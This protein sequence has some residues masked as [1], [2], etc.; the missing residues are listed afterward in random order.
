[1]QRNVLFLL[2]PVVLAVSLWSAVALAEPPDRETLEHDVFAVRRTWWLP[3]KGESF[4]GL[5]RFEPMTGEWERLRSL[6]F[7]EDAY[8]FIP[9]TRNGYGS[10]LAGAGDKLVFQA[11][12]ASQEWELGTWRLLQRYAPLPPSAVG[13]VI[14]GPVVSPD[15]ASRLQIPAG[16]YGLPA[17]L[18]PYLTG[19]RELTDPVPCAPHAFPGSQADL[20]E[21]ST[22]LLVVQDLESPRHALSGYDLGTEQWGLTPQYAVEAPP[23]LSTLPDEGVLI[24]GTPRSIQRWALAWPP[25]LESETTIGIPQ[26]GDPSVELDLLFFH[27]RRRRFLAGLRL[28]LKEGCPQ[29][30]E[31]VGF[32]SDFSNVDSYEKITDDFPVGLPVTL[33]W[34]GEQPTTHQQLVPIVSRTS[35]INNTFWTAELWLYNP[36]AAETTVTIRRVVK[37]DSEVTVTLPAR[38]SRRIPDALGWLGGGEAGDGVKAD[39]LVLTSPYR[40]GANLVA[41]A[42]VSTPAEGGGS[43]GQAVPAVPGVVGYSNHLPYY[44]EKMGDTYY[45]V[46]WEEWRPST[47][48]LDLREPG[49][50]RHNLGIVNDEDEPVEITLE[51]AY[52]LMAEQDPTDLRPAAVVQRVTA[53]AH[54]A[55]IVSLEGLFPPEVRDAWPPRVAVYA[56]RQVALWLSMV[57][58]LTGDATFIPYTNLTLH[59]DLDEDWHAVPVVAHSPGREGTFWTTALYGTEGR[60]LHRFDY[61]KPDA[62]FLPSDPAAACGGAALADRIAAVLQGEVGMPMDRW[63][64]TLRGVGYEPTEDW[65]KREWRTVFPDVV[66]LFPA[67]AAEDSTRGALEVRTGSWSAGFT[68]TSTTRADGGTYGSMLPFYPPHGWP[69]QHFAGIEVRA[70]WRVNLGLYNGQRDRAVVHRLSLYAADGTLAAQNE[71]T[72]SPGASLLEPLATIL[73]VASI[74]DGTYGLTVLPLD[75]PETGDQGTSWAYVSLVDNVTGDPTNWW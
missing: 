3:T 10:F 56:D 66:R 39:A 20:T 5:W 30:W 64:E 57:D 17:C 63:L 44:P 37:P 29:V 48:S 4:Q 23:V 53:P 28:P 68:R 52:N 36:S 33:A 12:P 41:A 24:R 14:Q 19:G 34:A 13:W 51:W 22:S 6:Y 54:S 2:S 1:M 74:P 50:F 42:R 61:D 59:T 43:Y 58:N 69:V 38:G 25:V 9:Y 73:G 16:T 21:S 72:L 26:F 55:H 11:W 46:F 27:P 31:F 45:G 15:L 70:E 7:N 60:F 35:G 49:R 40:W 47:F 65:A 71:L 8:G 32:Q 18:R 67:C 62:A 75:D